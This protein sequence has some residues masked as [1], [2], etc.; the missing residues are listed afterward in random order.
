M[1]SA[2]S[3]V[4]LSL[5]GSTECGDLGRWVLIVCMF[6]GRI[7]IITFL[8]SLFYRERQ[9]LTRYPQENILLY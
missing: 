2:L 1:I 4:G 8:W 7:G 6:L 5:G 3:T 9:T